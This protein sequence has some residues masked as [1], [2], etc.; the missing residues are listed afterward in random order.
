MSK[1]DIICVVR[2]HRWLSADQQA[3][4]FRE[5]G[6]CRAIVSLGGGKRIAQVTRADIERMVRR[7]TVVRV[8]HTFLLAEPKRTS[9]AM[10]DDLNE[11]IGGI[12]KRGGFI[13]DVESGLTSAEKGHWFAMSARAL[14]LI[15]KHCQ[16]A[17]SATNGK[18]QRGRS[19]VEFSDAQLR[20]AKAIWRNVKDYPTWEDAGKALAEI[21]SAACEK[22]TTDRAFKLWKGRK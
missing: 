15:G 2:D 22:F 4:A 18:R 13:E 21:R 5:R 14:E 12:A 3:K 10:R 1:E 17:R 7:G 19:L 8:M 16:G 11:A 6:D 9:T 20:D